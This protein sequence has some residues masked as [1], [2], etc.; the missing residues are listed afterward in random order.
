[1]SYQYLARFQLHCLCCRLLLNSRAAHIQTQN[2]SP[3]GCRLYRR[4]GLCPPSHPHCLL[5]R[6]HLFF[7]PFCSAIASC[8]PP[9]N[10]PFD[11]RLG[12]LVIVICF[13]DSMPL[14]HC[15]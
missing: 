7:S 5:Q 6:A 2:R 15:L 4:I 3:P 14:R 11:F 9:V 12:C 1:M 13:D 8:F 10:I